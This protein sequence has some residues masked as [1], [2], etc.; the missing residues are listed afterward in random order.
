[1]P[2]LSR[3][4]SWGIKPCVASALIVAAIVYVVYLPTLGNGFV[5]FDDLGYI[6]QNTAIR[7]LDINLLNW[8]FWGFH[9]QFYIPFTWVSFAV[10]YHFW[11]LDPKGYHL[12]NNFLHALNSGWV[13]LICREL[14]D[15]FQNRQQHDLISATCRESW[16]NVICLVAGLMFGLHPLRVE[17]VAWATERKDVLS[18]FFLLPAMIAY[19]RFAREKSGKSNSTFN[20]WFV[21]SLCLFFF[22]LLSKP[23]M[24]G[25]PLVLLCF[26]WYPLNRL[27]NRKELL[28]AVKE[29]IPFLCLAT[30]FLV[31]TLFSQLADGVPVERVSLVSRLLIAGKSLISYLKMMIWPSGLVPLYPHPGNAASLGRFEYVWPLVAICIISVIAMRLAVRNNRKWLWLWLYF[32]ITLIPVLGVT[33]VG[34][35]AMAD[36][37]T[38]LPA[39]C[40]TVMAILLFFRIPFH[41]GS[42]DI[43]CLA[44]IGLIAVIILTVLCA[45]VTI[46]RELMAVWRNSET[47]WSRVIEIKPMES[48]DAYHH[49]GYFYADNG[50]Y[51]KALDDMNS[52]IIVAETRQPHNL[53]DAYFARADILMKMNRPQEAYR[54]FAKTRELS[55]RLNRDI[56]KK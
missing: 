28:C 54:D 37:F 31:L 2:P 44:V 9:Q 50:D 26:D 51:E 27:T 52:S 25:M 15:V 3:T 34:P 16:K 40:P 24:L 56:R 43:K 47:M 6:L 8:A 48:A 41:F 7:S 32:L 42:G 12:T 17:S 21:L 49:R 5:N 46:S 38:Y 35:Q 13:V 1:M 55:L 53:P 18:A 39:I 11:G 22:S 19:I 14:I 36:R 4:M 20:S 45:Y 23:I 10:D 29:K 30:L 33:Q